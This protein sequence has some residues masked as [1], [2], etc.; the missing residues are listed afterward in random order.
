MRVKGYICG[1]IISYIQNVW[2]ISLILANHLVTSTVLW[3]SVKISIRNYLELF[4]Q[5]EKILI[6]STP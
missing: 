1:Q 5:I 3:F 6:K 2:K 4:F